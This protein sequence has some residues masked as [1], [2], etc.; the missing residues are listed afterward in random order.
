M[1][2]RVEFDKRASKDLENLD[3]Q[4]RQRVIRKRYILEREPARGPNIKR[5]KGY[6]NRYRLRVGDWRLVYEIEGDLV[7]VVGIM[8]R[9]DAYR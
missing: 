8:H 6:P 3:P 5:L 1:A 4:V 9:S 2:Y 7:I